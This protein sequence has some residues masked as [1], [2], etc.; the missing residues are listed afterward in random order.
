[1]QLSR[2]RLRLAGWFVLAFLLGLV[3]L[4]S[5]LYVYLRRQNDL[6]LTR[7]LGRTS[8]EL[9]EAIRIEFDHNPGRGLPRAAAETLV[10]WPARPQAFA[11]YGAGGNRIAFRGD[12]DFLGVAP[13]RLLPGQ[14]TRVQDVVS[15][16]EQRL[17]AVTSRSPGKPEFVL[18][19]LGSTAALDDQNQALAVW[20]AF[21]TPLAAV[22][23]LI[24]GYLLS[25][26]ALRPIGALA[27]VV[28]TI[29]PD[30]LERRL[31]VHPIAD[32]L[33]R[34]AEQ[35]N[36][37]LER[38]QRAQAQNRRFLQQAAHQIKT[39]LTLVLGEAALGQERRGAS[40]DQLETLQRIRT[41]A[42]QMK[43][44]VD[45]LFLLAQA[46][47]GERLDLSGTIELDGLAL[48]CADLMR[49]RAQALG[50]RLQL[51]RVEPVSVRGNETLLREAVL[52]LIENACRYGSS[53]SS[54]AISAFA[55][56]RTGCVL[57]A[58]AGEAVGSSP[59]DPA[60]SDQTEGAHGLGL[61]IVRWIASAHSGSMTYQR[62][63]GV[64]VYG[65][66]LPAIT[67]ATGRMVVLAS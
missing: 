7:A 23:S 31:P 2:L 53:N 56:G 4:D 64:N 45:E 43:R 6:R 13:A 66:L 20:F 47:A 19:T 67:V 49:G 22:L 38:L 36:A 10:E 41:A 42:E 44:R 12:A 18:L 25:R 46:E 33:D 35:F 17:R 58:S 39:P 24:G 27:D 55:T 37:L 63:G 29:T 50:R 65:L 51:L 40:G 52:E 8:A 14:W 34:L 30:Q 11:I 54:I 59:A 48:E 60:S 9:V 32:E 57:V 5:T 3:V 15:P 62:E 1:M 21:S 61:A 26:R 16:G 28:A